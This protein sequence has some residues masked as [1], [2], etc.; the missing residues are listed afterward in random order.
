MQRKWIVEGRR[1]IVYSFAIQ[2]SKQKLVIKFCVLVARRWL[3]LSWMERC[4]YI[5]IM[6]QFLDRRSE[7]I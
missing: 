6:S 4:N 7:Q 2:F 5:F 1:K 3:I